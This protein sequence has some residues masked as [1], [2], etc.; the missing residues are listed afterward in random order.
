MS[1]D[2]CPFCPEAGARLF[3]E[4][5]AYRNPTAGTA[6]FFQ[7]L[8]CGL[9]YPRP[10]LDDTEVQ[11]YVGSLYGEGAGSAPA[12][13]AAPLRLFNFELHVLRKVARR[14]HLRTGLDIGCNTGY[15]MKLMEQ[16]GIRAAGL[17]ASEP[18]VRAARADGLQVYRGLFPQEIP[19][20][21]GQAKFD[22]LAMN[23]VIC[24]FT[25]LAGALEKARD[26]LTGNGVLY[27]KIY[28][29]EE[30]YRKDG[31]SFFAKGGD[32]LQSV[33]TN[34]SLTWC[35]QHSGFGRVEIIPYPD[36]LDRKYGR[37]AYPAKFLDF[38]RYYF[39]VAFRHQAALDRATRVI[40][41][42]EPDGS[43]E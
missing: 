20:E 35:L 38:A 22:L 1:L 9:I 12:P 11:E 43:S 19:D 32:Y 34:A 21:V 23:E 39:D 5:Q 42:A 2:T 10:R 26:L 18:M 27:I 8:T 37:Y 7:C 14:R 4:K 15:F 33:F 16:A 40:V 36:F 29:G 6:D 30:I 41:L 31:R 13:Q 24:Y 25:D 17:E 3:R 28:L